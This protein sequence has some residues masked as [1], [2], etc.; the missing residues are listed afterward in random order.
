V[1]GS[2]SPSI[3]YSFGTT[4]SAENYNRLMTRRS[5]AV[6]DDALDRVQEYRQLLGYR[7]RA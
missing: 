5:H 6:G 1:S 7:R 3:R 4:F 2:G